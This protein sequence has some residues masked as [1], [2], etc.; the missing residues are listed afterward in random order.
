MKRNLLA[1][2]TTA[3]L[4]TS[5]ALLSATAAEQ[6]LAPEAAMANLK[7]VKT[8]P[9][10]IWKQTVEMSMQGFSMPPR[11]SEM[12]IAKN[13]R[14]EDLYRGDK[15][16]RVYDVQG[17]GNSFSAKMRCDGKE[18]MEGTIQSTQ[19]GN[20]TRGVTTMHPV[21]KPDEGMTMKF[22]STRTGQACEAKDY[23]S[24]ELPKQVA[25]PKGPD[26]EPFCRQQLADV[27]KNPAM[28]ARAVGI[29]VGSGAP[30]AKSPTQKTFC[31]A[32]QTHGG[33]LGLDVGERKMAEFTKTSDVKLSESDPNTMPLTAALR[34]CGAA[35]SA[36]DVDALRS[37][38]K[39]SAEA[40][41]AYDFMI[42]NGGDA[43][44][45]KARDFAKRECSGSAYTS[46]KDP[47]YAGFCN[48]LGLALALNN[49]RGAIAIIDGS[50]SGDCG[51][52]GADPTS[53]AAGARGAAAG[54]GNRGASQPGAA[55]DAAPASP[56]DLKKEAA[57]EA[58]K[59]AVD[60]GKR[61]LRG[62]LG[63]G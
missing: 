61:L 32:A 52:F 26:L 40:Q 5:A 1:L 49:R 25:A 47:K 10:E 59:E 54:N 48:S 43:E 57:K 14:Q 15:D 60:K 34:G 62:L 45:A 33:F 28:S 19:E 18:P 3:A 7:G 4:V 55:P 9:G 53:S 63:G 35:K 50:C 41:G 20:R 46:A 22:D 36:A 11:N 38:L 21:G 12:C 31:A 29:Y 37:R 16:C 39:D 17:S 58:A 2:A 42:Y 30:C 8:V 24:I 6:R 56:T 23:S 27:Q 44:F 51:T 13:S